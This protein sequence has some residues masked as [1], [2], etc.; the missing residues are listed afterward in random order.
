[1]NRY[2]LKQ[3]LMLIDSCRIC[4]ICQYLKTMI[5]LDCRTL[6]IW[7]KYDLRNLKIT[8]QVTFIIQS[9]IFVFLAWISA[10]SS[11]RSLSREW[12]TRGD[13]W[14]SGYRFPWKVIATFQGSLPKEVYK[15]LDTNITWPILNILTQ[16]VYYE[17]PSNYGKTIK[18]LV[19]TLQRCSRE[20]SYLQSV[21]GWPWRFLIYSNESFMSIKERCKQIVTREK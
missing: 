7:M 17:R 11:G 19:L 15:I 12:A 20:N 2:N 1:M 9:F 4:D 14:N 18:L 6:L 13:G 10:V 5:I 8:L 16:F 21:L 3:T